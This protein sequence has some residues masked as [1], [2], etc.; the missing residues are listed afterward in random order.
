MAEPAIR[1]PH[2]PHDES[3]ERITRIER[4]DGR[5]RMKNATTRRQNKGTRRFYIVQLNLTASPTSP[6]PGV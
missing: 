5:E 3:R 4:R 1:P 2:V 6:S